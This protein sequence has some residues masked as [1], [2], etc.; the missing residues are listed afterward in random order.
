MPLARS[1]VV[2]ELNDGDSYTITISSV[3]KIIGGKALRMLA[4]NGSIP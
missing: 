4:Y 1:P 2:V 3:Q